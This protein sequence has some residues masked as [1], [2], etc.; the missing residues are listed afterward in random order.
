M[1]ETLREL[2]KL[3]AR[4]PK[5][6]FRLICGH[7]GGLQFEAVRKSGPG[8]SGLYALISGSATEMAAELK[9]AA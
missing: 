4:F 2:G 3:K 5:F 8:D 6:E 7:C 1:L 9:R